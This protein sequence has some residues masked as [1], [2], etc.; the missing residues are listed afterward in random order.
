MCLVGSQESLQKALEGRRGS[1]GQGVGSSQ[2]GIW[3]SLGAN[4]HFSPIY[5][6]P[7]DTLGQDYSEVWLQRESSSPT[8]YGLRHPGL[9]QLSPAQLLL[10]SVNTPLAPPQFGAPRGP[11]SH[12]VIPISW[13]LGKGVEISRMIPVHS[14]AAPDTLN[15]SRARHQH[16]HRQQ[17]HMC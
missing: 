6:G 10:P 4:T 17:A 11:V 12:R 15:F 3:S 8:D 2:T 14:K 7:G 9:A 16:K 5:I 1:C 13:C